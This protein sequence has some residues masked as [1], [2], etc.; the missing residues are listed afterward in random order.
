MPEHILPLP[1]KWERDV[2]CAWVVFKNGADE[3]RGYFAKP[4]DGADLPGIV[5]VHENLGII[6]HRQDVTRRLAKAGYAC[7]TVD[8]YS[9][10]GGQSPR[11]FSSPQERRIKAFKAMPD[12]QVIPDLEAGLGYLR[13]RGDVDG[14]HIGAIGY[15]SGGGQ[16]FGWACG[17]AT[18]L[19]CA[20]VF[21]GS[22]EVGAESRPN[23]DAI[24]RVTAAHRLACPMQIH[25]GNA[26]KVVPMGRAY[27][28]VE[29]LKKSG[30]PVEFYEYDGADH[31]YHDDTHPAYHAVASEASWARTLEFFA[32]HLK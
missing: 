4:K 15:C 5:M 3:I 13:G 30:Q 17:N 9:R 18:G 27:E 26:D 7:L 20:V 10:I 19:A 24:D 31:A 6:E 1:P 22:L 16:L 21:Y 32:R 29:G 12:E 8:L 2:D 14:S 25:Q 28:M 23:G 11:D